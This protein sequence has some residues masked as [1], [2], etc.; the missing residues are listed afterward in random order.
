MKIMTI[1]GTR[2]EII[3]LSLVIPLL[4]K[5]NEHVLVNTG[6]NYAKELN[7]LFFEELSLREPDYDLDT[8]SETT[9]EQISKILY[10][11]EKIILKEKLVFDIFLLLLMSA[12]CLCHLKLII[13]PVFPLI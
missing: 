12:H 13:F 7:K 8:R 10:E 5:Y 6:Q 3:R 4:D 11:C 1:L 9:F 2:P